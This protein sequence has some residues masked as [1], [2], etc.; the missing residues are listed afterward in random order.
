VRLDDDGTY[1][2]SKVQH[3]L[4]A[5]WED[6][7]ATAATMRRRAK[8]LLYTEFNGDFFDG[9]HHHTSQIVSR[10]PE[11]CAY[12]SDRVLSVPHKLKPDRTFFVRGT[13]THVGP[14]GA[15]EEALARRKK[16]ERNPATRTWS[17][18]HLRTMGQRPWTEASVVSLLAA[19]IFYEHSRQRAKRLRIQPEQKAP[20]TH[21]HFAIRSHLHKHHDTAEA[22]P[23]RVIATPAWQVKTAYAHKVVPESLADVGGILILVEPNGQVEVVTKLYTP[24]L[25]PS[26]EP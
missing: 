23:T 24:E 25:P 4:W 26:W 10:N 3:W 12:I 2:P 6:Y 21:P 15:S 19:Q 8:A 22:H 11:P 17:W 20:D 9:D 14:S 7:W 16:A 5:C 13:E 1:Q 18:W